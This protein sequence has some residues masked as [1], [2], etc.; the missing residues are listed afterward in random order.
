M[1]ERGAEFQNQRYVQKKKS[2]D[3]QVT[4]SGKVWEEEQTGWVEKS[5]INEESKSQHFS[6]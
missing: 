6:P 2:Q 4:A 5:L 3:T 1:K